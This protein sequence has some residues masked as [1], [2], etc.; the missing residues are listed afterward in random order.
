MKRT[1]VQLLVALAL[2]VAA[3]IGLAQAS[4]DATTEDT[5]RVFEAYTE[6]HDP[7]HFAEDATFTDMTNPGQPLV[8]REAIGAYLATIYGQAF[9]DITADEVELLVDGNVV[10]LEFLFKGEHTGEFFGIPATGKRVELPMMSV[11]HIEDGLI[12]SARLYYDSMTMM[13][14]LGLA[15]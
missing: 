7:S 14:Q 3:G 6:A 11:Y 2:L 9:T 12:R 5:R 8:G 13:R 1:S 10:M 4:D 15:E